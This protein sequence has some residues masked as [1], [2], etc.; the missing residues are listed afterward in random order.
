[1]GNVISNFSNLQIYSCGAPK[2]LQHCYYLSYEIH[3][4]RR[5]VINICK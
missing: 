1:M 4:K 3:E 2:V 5:D